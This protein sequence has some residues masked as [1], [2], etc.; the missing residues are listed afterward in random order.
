MNF[1]LN[2]TL[3]NLIVLD[4]PVSLW[5]L[6]E[7]AIRRQFLMVQVAAWSFVTK[8]SMLKVF[9][10]LQ[11]EAWSIKIKEVNANKIVQT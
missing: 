5:F 4:K 11:I 6:Q 2:L 3:K 10:S 1:A 9:P 8:V 7:E